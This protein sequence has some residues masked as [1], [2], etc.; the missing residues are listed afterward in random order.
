M[1]ELQAVSHTYRIGDQRTSAIRDVDF[2]V[3][4]GEIVSIA[5]PSGSGKSTMLSIMGCLLTPDSGAVRIMGKD[6]SLQ[7]DATKAEIRRLHI[8]FIFQSFNLIPVL[9]AFENIE[10][11][12][13]IGGIVGAE[14]KR[15]VATILERV[16][17]AQHQTK[18]P[19]QLSGGQKQRVA[20]ARALV[21][22]P[23]FVLA[24]EPTANLDSHT[25]SEILA[26]MSELNRE[27]KTALIFSTHDPKVS[28]FAHKQ[29]RLEDGKL[30]A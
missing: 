1:I 19:D 26:L 2:T 7:C 23:G 10:Y 8:G 3:E 22:N 5:G 29:V 4:E 24:D 21:T 16:G 14:R 27:L 13:I 30:V 28:A 6:M 12:L 15:R 25:A 9:S 20:I 18:R 11:P 17:L